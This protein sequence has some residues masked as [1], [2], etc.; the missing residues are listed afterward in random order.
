MPV[1]RGFGTT[2]LCPLHASLISRLSCLLPSWL[3]IKPGF[4][5]LPALGLW[6]LGRLG[7]GWVLT[8]NRG[9][10]L[11]LSGSPCTLGE[12]ADGTG[13]GL[14]QESAQPQTHCTQPPQPPGARTCPSLACCKIMAL[15]MRGYYKNFIAES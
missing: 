8:V 5:L 7:R 4:S 14:Q 13:L 6:L 2:E 10:T 12:G 11:V 9:D 3:P 1:V 15:V